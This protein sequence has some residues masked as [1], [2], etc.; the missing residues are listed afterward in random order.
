[1]QVK[2]EEVRNK[3]LESSKKLFIV[4]GFTD[5]SI[6][7]IACD[8]G[9]SVA[10]IYNYYESK[11]ELLNEIVKSAINSYEK[12]IQENSTEEIWRDPSQWNVQ[13]ET[14]RIIRFFRMMAKHRDEFQIMLNKAEGTNLE[15]YYEK[16][17]DTLTEARTKIA[18]NAIEGNMGLIKRRRPKYLTR[19]TIK[20][21]LDVVLE[22]FRD[23]LSEAEIIEK[24]KEIAN[25][26]FFGYSFYLE[27][28]V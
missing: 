17:I 19:I 18:Q 27:P 7:M 22:G 10:N 21:Y 28:N 14:V 1:M 2:K 20:I 11:E 5:T 26:M 23:N 24:L 4:N 15:G 12:F 25:F 13:S 3:I 6:K 16:M 9:I 8:A